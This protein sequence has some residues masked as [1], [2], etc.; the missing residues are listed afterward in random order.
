MVGHR[1]EDDFIEVNFYSKTKDK[2][3]KMLEVLHVIKVEE[4]E[5]FIKPPKINYVSRTR[6]FLEFEGLDDVVVT[7]SSDTSFDI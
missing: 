6:A 1:L 5:K 3:W 7:E 4:I 2:G